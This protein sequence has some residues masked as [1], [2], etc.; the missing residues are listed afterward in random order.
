[1]ELD[2]DVV[3]ESEDDEPT[4]SIVTL[5]SATNGTVRSKS[6]SQASPTKKGAKRSATLLEEDSDSGVVFKGFG[7]KKKAR[8]F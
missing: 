5:R 2:L 4:G 8:A 3:K 7:G 6:R 1:M